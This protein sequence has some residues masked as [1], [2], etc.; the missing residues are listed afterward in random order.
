MYGDSGENS[1]LFSSSCFP[2]SC[3][4][5][6]GFGPILCDSGVPQTHSREQKEKGQDLAPGKG[7]LPDRVPP[8]AECSEPS[9]SM[10]A[11]SY[12]V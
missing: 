12:S 11:H 3:F 7:L 9:A 5:P 8:S 6:V 1:H 4:L 10:Q 2:H